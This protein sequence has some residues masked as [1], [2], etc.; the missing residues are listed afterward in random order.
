MPQEL[1]QLTQAYVGRK[2]STSPS[3]L[4]SDGFA[5]PMDVSTRGKPFGRQDDIDEPSED[6]KHEEPEEDLG[7]SDDEFADF[8]DTPEPENE[9]PKIA[10]K[11]SATQPS[12][13]SKKRK[14]RSFEP[15][16]EQEAVEKPAVIQCMGANRKKKIR[17]RNAALMEF[18]GP[19]PLYCA[20]HIS[21]DPNAMY[22]KCGFPI[23]EMPHVKVKLTPSSL[24]PNLAF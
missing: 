9:E 12:S 17:C 22:H 21:S 10:P 2:P 7:E 20:E 8:L 11:R 23:S 18:V 4:D 15:E 5:K 6:E 14:S 1:I 19:Q 13:R 3:L 16:D 24:L